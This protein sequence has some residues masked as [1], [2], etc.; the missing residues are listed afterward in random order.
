MNSPQRCTFD[1]ALYKATQAS[2]MQT[3]MPSAVAW[4]P[5]ISSAVMSSVLSWPMTELQDTDS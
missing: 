5:A 3:A 4:L 2:W 1:A